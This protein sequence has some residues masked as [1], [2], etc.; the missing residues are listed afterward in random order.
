MTDSFEADGVW[1]IPPNL[2]RRSTGTLKY[3]PATG[4]ELVNIVGTMIPMVANLPAMHPEIAMV[5]GVTHAGRRYTCLKAFL[6]GHKVHQPGSAVSSLSIGT[7]FEGRHFD[8][9]EDML[10]RR[11]RFNYSN[12]HK[13]LLERPP[14]KVEN[15]AGITKLEYLRTVLWKVDV[16]GLA[17]QHS[18]HWS[19]SSDNDPTPSFSFRHT[20]GLL[21][22]A[23]EPSP[24]ETFY[25]AERIFRSFVNLLGDCQIQTAQVQADLGTLHTDINVYDRGHFFINERE[26]PP[27]MGMPVLYSE[28]EETFSALL[29]QWY[30]LHAELK[31]VINL[32]LF[33]KQNA[34]RD[35]EN[36]FLGML[37]T[38]EGFHRSFGAGQYMPEP[39]YSQNIKP[40]LTNAIPG[41]LPDGFKS[42][43]RS[44]LKWAYEYSL[45]KK[46]EELIGSLPATATFDAVRA[47]AFVGRTIDTRNYF[48][49]RD[50]ASAHLALQGVD[51]IRASFLWEEIV[52]ALLLKKLGLD[53]AVIDRA[54]R[55]LKDSRSVAD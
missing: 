11:F 53:D 14:F 38:A 20:D 51:L 34:H 6:S 44:M 40:I 21:I 27:Y 16:D 28:I 9:P 5:H 19:S 30:S 23:S 45:R 49:H 8:S 54:I 35:I 2:E 33:A 36:G 32:Y 7:V 13:Y 43:L 3:H 50:A 47:P 31:S 48:T 52:L 29:A 12:L 42:K 25:G 24:A 46:L 41:N 22:T 1:W 10:F 39:E 17:V 15:E 37:Q 26:D 4:A 55:R 18:Y